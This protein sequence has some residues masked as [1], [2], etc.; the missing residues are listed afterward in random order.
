MMLFPVVT[1]PTSFNL[2]VS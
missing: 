2:K 1:L